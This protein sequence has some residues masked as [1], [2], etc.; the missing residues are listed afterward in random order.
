MS[1]GYAL[2][3]VP[4]VSSVLPIWTLGLVL[5]ASPGAHAQLLD[6]VLVA[7]GLASPLFVTAPSLDSRLFIVERE[8]RVRIVKDGALLPTPFLDIQGRVN[9][10]SGERG[11]LGLAF[12]PDY[13]ASGEFYVYF[14]DQSGDSVISRFAVGADPDVADTT[15]TVILLVDQPAE[16]HNGG[17]IVFDADGFL[18]AALGDGGGS[19]D[20]DERAQDP[21]ELLGKMLRIDVGSPIAPG[22]IPVAGENYAIPADNPWASST[23]GVRDEIWA[24]GLRNPYRFSV[25]RLTGDLWIADVGQREREE[26]DFESADDPGGR[27][28]GW[29]VMEGSLCNPNDPAP[30]PPCNDPALSLPI[31]EYGHDQGRCSITGG[32]AFRGPGIPALEGHYFYGDFCSGEIWSL[33]LG[34]GITDR[35]AELGDAGTG[36]FDLVGFGED[37]LGHLHVV[38]DSGEVYRIRRRA[39]CQDGI[40]NDGDLLIDLAD[41]GCNGN[42]DRDR[43]TAR[44]RCGAGVSALLIP[45]FVG[46]RR[47]R[48]RRAA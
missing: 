46:V 29:D 23:D 37:G 1:T 25:D 34:V 39:R 40:D 33:E 32:Y 6:S 13:A 18:L 21:N 9:K 47:R 2:L 45:L 38:H 17:T 7:S 22:S 19:N 48:W 36:G 41:P 20:P 31:H 26:I 5:L 30:A 16:N 27:N 14:T 35:T 8:G 28:W 12:A 10:T 3:V 4:R 24:F 44:V 42:P 43:E 15:E 11:L